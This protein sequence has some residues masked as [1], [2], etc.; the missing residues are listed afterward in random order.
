M[1]IGLNSAVSGTKV[2][3]REEPPNEP[4]AL[5]GVTAFTKT[6]IG[7][8][9]FTHN[10]YS[11]STLC[12]PPVLLEP[13]MFPGEGF[14]HSDSFECLPSFL[15]RGVFQPSPLCRVR[16]KSCLWHCCLLFP[17]YLYADERLLCFISVWNLLVFLADSSCPVAGNLV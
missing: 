17:P 8:H 14:P 7:S 6:K 11:D 10:R 9:L 13:A 2:M 4:S 3:A 15:H 16:R 12:H 1:Q 5:L